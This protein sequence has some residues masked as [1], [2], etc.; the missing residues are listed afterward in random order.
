MHAFETTDP[1]L[2]PYAERP[3]TTVIFRR[4]PKTDGG[5]LIALFPYEFDDY[6]GL[7]CASY[8]HVGQHGAA[9]YT[10]LTYCT[11]LVRADEPDVVE[12]TRE[13]ET[14]GYRL[15]RAQRVNAARLAAARRAFRLHL[16]TSGRVPATHW[17]EISL[18]A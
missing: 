12:L 11:R 13:L 17:P 6:Q 18:P 9:R 4:F 8:M 7:D 14:I 5:Q 2:V 1:S 15:G 3:A 10:A 16:K